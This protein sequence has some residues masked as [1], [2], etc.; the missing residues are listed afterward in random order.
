MHNAAA[1]GGPSSRPLGYLLAF[2]AVAGVVLL[3]QVAFP[4]LGRDTPFLLTLL[5]V[6]VATWYGGTGPGFFAALLSCVATLFVLLSP[7][8][9]RRLS[10]AAALQTIA[11]VV[12]STLVVCLITG[13]WVARAR[14]RVAAGRVAR[15]HAVSSELGKVRTLDEVTQVI[16]HEAVTALEAAAGVVFLVRAPSGPLELVGQFHDGTGRTR[17]AFDIPLDED[18]PVALAARTGEAVFFESGEELDRRFPCIRPAWR[19][20]MPPAAMCLPMMV[21]GRVVGVLG[22]AFAE[23]RCFDPQERFWAQTLAQDC[24]MAIERARLFEAERKARIKAEE[25]SR[26]KDGFLSIASHELRAPLTSILGWTS[27]L[28]STGPDDRTRLARG[29]DV[30]ERS[31]RAQARLVDDIL[32]V[33]R[34]AAGKLTIHPKPMRLGPLVRSCLEAARATADARGVELAIVLDDDAAVLGDAD[35]LRQV[36]DNL[37][38]NALKFTPRGGHV[39]IESDRVDGKC[40][41]R[42]RDDGKGISPGDIAHVFEAFRQADSS[43]TRREGGLGLGLSIV[44]HIVC[45]H[46]GSVRIDS[47]GVGCGA[48]VTVELPA[49]DPVPGP[50]A[51]G[52]APQH[53]GKATLGGLRVLVVDDDADARDAV[54]EML[55]AQGAQV[56]SAP[57]AKA[58]LLALSAFSPNAIVSDIGM[59]DE[60]GYWL[61]RKVRALATNVATV[62]AVALTAYSR[63]EDVRAAMA[64]GYQ[65]HLA[66]PPEP[67]RLA[68]VVAHLCAHAG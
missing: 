8:H 13:V 61:M 46:H 42:V 37:L 25:A 35:R 50:R 68:N 21:H 7:D 39:G 51:A 16:L 32:D 43:S 67:E 45:E 66:K 48:T 17:S 41:L 11:F 31:A 36:V 4:A 60:D 64:A 38:A 2:V 23:R 54:A 24:G 59:P 9:S 34:I 53:A 5:P 10:P 6:V 29:L 19:A 57:S 15:I 20:S 33:A 62:P 1:K 58:A 27:L 22:I 56:K 40:L 47:A 44:K 63:P 28:K 26:A 3:K 30:I 49:A 52:A 14:A 18:F 55:A 65:E 12:Q